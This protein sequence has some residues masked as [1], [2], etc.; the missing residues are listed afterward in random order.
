MNFFWNFF[1]QFFSWFSISKLSVKICSTYDEKKKFIWKK[2]NISFIERTKIDF[3]IT[4]TSSSNLNQSKISWFFHDFS[5]FKLQSAPTQDKLLDFLQQN[6][7]KLNLL[8]KAF[9]S[10]HFVMMK[11]VS[12]WNRARTS[13]PWKKLFEEDLAL[14]NHVAK[15]QGIYLE[16][17]LM[18]TLNG[19]KSW[20]FILVEIW[21]S[22]RYDMKIIYGAFDK[23]DV[24]LLSHKIF[25]HHMNYRFLKKTLKLKSAKKL[26]KKFQKKFKSASR[27]HLP[28]NIVFTVLRWL[29]QRKLCSSSVPLVLYANPMLKSQFATQL[30]FVCIVML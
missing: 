1:S 5:H 30:Q 28:P 7:S 26:R 4:P 11:K 10:R 17:G 8:Q 29:Y 15:S 13:M 23:V 6:F 27:R 20:N 16:S 9:V 22:C 12:M 24:R 3:H 14:K 18:E 2:P 21:S 19:K 25:F